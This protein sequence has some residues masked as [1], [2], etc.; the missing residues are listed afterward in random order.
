M[1]VIEDQERYQ[2][3]VRVGPVTRRS[4]LEKRRDETRR[5]H[6]DLVSSRNFVSR[7]GLELKFLSRKKNT[8]QK[9]KIL[10]NLSQFFSSFLLGLVSRLVLWLFVSRPN[11]RDRLVSR[12]VS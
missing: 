7:D 8:E 2:I 5:D 1:E 10:G 12:L 3:Q 9:V 4:R 6:L 11:S